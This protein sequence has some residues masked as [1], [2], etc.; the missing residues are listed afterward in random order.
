[1]AVRAI[2][3]F[4]DWAVRAV[5]VYAPKRSQTCVSTVIRLYYGGERWGMFCIQIYNRR[6]QVNKYDS[7]R[8]EV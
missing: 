4:T 7:T 5:M 1:M 2:Y 6:N 8:F 3:I